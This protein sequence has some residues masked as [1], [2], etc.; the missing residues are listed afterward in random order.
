MTE[1]KFMKSIIIK[2]ILLLTLSSSVYAQETPVKIE[3]KHKAKDEATIQKIVT[4]AWSGWSK[5]DAEQA[6]TEYS[7]DAYWINAFGIEKRGKAEIKMF[8]TNIYFAVR[9]SSRQKSNTDAHR[10]D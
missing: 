4:D 9:V 10:F 6:V 1:T 3:G 2:F 7:D 8:L 5:N